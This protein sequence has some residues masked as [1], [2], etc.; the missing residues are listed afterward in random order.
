MIYSKDK[1]NRKK[2]LDIILGARD[3]GFIVGNYV[4]FHGIPCK[5][6]RTRMFHY[7]YFH[8][9]LDESGDIYYSPKMEGVQYP[10]FGIY[11]KSHDRTFLYPH[12]I[13]KTVG[14]NGG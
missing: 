13:L 4:D 10:C 5:I 12:T 7:D 8:E 14:A 2:A 9:L 6:Q 11:F 3:D 1:K